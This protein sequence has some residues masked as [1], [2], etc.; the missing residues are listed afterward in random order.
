MGGKKALL[1]HK[2]TKSALEKGAS[3]KKL[4]FLNRDEKGL[5]RSKGFY[6]L[7]G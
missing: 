3:K 5:E 6:G 4:D 2:T 7:K 1:T